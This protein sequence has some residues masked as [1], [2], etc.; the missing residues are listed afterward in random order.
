MFK[1]QNLFRILFSAA[2]LPYNSQ[3]PSDFFGFYTTGQ[4]AEIRCQH[5]APHFSLKAV[6]VECSTCKV[7]KKLKHQIISTNEFQVYD[8]FGSLVCRSFVLVFVHLLGLEY[9]ECVHQILLLN[10]EGET[11]MKFLA[12]LNLKSVLFK[13]FYSNAAILKLRYFHL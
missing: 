5:N 7:W 10:E 9:R 1:L 12:Y 4:T 6:G 8:L 11:V 13:R 2:K 3:F